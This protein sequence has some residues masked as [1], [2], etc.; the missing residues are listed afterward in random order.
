[1]ARITAI[2]LDRAPENAR[3][4]QDAKDMAGFA[5]ASEPMGRR[6]SKANSFKLPGDVYTQRRGKCAA[7]TQLTRLK[8]PQP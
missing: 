1:M 7:L 5:A 6:R 2:F 3:R 8:R 4:R